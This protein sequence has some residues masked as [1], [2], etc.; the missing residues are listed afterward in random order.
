[1]R[2]SALGPPSPRQSVFPLLQRRL[3]PPP[4][5]RVHPAP[6]G[7]GAVLA[8][9]G[10]AS[11]LLFPLLAFPGLVPDPRLPWPLRPVCF[12]H[13]DYQFLKGAFGA[14]TRASVGLWEVRGWQGRAW[15]KKAHDGRGQLCECACGPR[16]LF[17][18]LHKP[19]A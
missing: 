6:T 15:L 14:S 8:R 7:A 11:E 4:A 2:F 9:L 13:R 5:V 17:P 18:G 16:S 3:P 1:M 19:F 12:R 10:G